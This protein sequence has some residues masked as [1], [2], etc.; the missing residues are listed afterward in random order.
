[1]LFEDLKLAFSY[2]EKLLYW[3]HRVAF[4]FIHAYL[5]LHHQK[6]ASCMTRPSSLRILGWFYVLKKNFRFGLMNFYNL[7]ENFMQREVQVLHLAV[8][9]C[10]GRAALSRALARKSFVSATFAVGGGN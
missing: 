4:I 2:E 1:M 9:P 8:W 5:V 10:V 6:R 7:K 3:T